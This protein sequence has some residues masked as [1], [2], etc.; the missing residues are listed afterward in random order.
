MTTKRKPHAS[1]RVAFALKL[2]RKTLR[3]A[4]SFFGDQVAS[5]L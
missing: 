5:F 4:G 2:N 1:R 3:L